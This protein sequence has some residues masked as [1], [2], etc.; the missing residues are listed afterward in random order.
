MLQP[1]FSIAESQ[2]VAKLYLPYSRSRAEKWYGEAE[3]AV[4]S[5]ALRVHRVSERCV[6]E[7]EELGT[8][9]K[10]GLTPAR[11]VV[12]R[13]HCTA[14]NLDNLG[15]RLCSVANGTGQTGHG[16]ALCTVWSTCTYVRTYQVGSYP[17]S[18]AGGGGCWGMGPNDYPRVLIRNRRLA[19]SKRSGPARRNRK[20]QALVTE[21][22]RKRHLGKPDRATGR[23]RCT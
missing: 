14:D 18:R 4:F 7:P 16:C 21:F 11:R 10:H 23:I 19:R 20:L 1:P 12:L 6:G 9:I 8:A 13:A 17:I 15:K 22:T 2:V 5:Q 3:V